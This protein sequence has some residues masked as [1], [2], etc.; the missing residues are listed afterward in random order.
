[1]KTVTYTA[2]I[3][4]MCS[5]LKMTL[6]FSVAI[7]LKY[8]HW[9]YETG[10]TTKV[11]MQSTSDVRVSH[12]ALSKRLASSQ[13]KSVFHQRSR[14]VEGVAARTRVAACYGLASGNQLQARVAG[15]RSGCR[16][17]H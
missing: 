7:Q 9:T 2:T 5:L 14:C 15:R 6:S 17:N 8:R 13:W 1:P 10:T 12:A 11:W 3:A 4:V 16:C